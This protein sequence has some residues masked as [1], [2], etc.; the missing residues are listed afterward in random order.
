MSDIVRTLAEVLGYLTAAWLAVGVLWLRTSLEQFCDNSYVYD[1]RTD[2]CEEIDFRALS[3]SLK[4]WI[5][6]KLVTAWPDAIILSAPEE[7]DDNA[8]Q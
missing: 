3:F 2:Q 4:A 8:E 5:V 7:G 6:F 1:E